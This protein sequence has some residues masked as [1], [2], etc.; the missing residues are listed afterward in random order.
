M[1][2]YF[3]RWRT[4]GKQRS[5]GLSPELRAHRA[6]HLEDPIA[7]G[8]ICEQIGISPRHLERL[9]KMQLGKS[10]KLYYRAKRL[11]AAR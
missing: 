6:G 9:F 1:E 3:R 4:G 5:V 7:V 2:P 8:D 11:D 10:H